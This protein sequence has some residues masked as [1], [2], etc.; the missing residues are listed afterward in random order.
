MRRPNPISTLL[1]I[2]CSGCLYD[3]EGTQGLPCNV[4]A[5]CGAQVCVD[6]VCGGGAALTVADTEPT[7]GTGDESTGS[8]EGPTA[9]QLPEPCT[10]GHQA[11]LGS[12]AMEVCDDDG[13]LYSFA[14][15]AWCG[16]GNPPQGS[17]QADPRDGVESCWCASQGGPP[18][19]TCGNSCTYDGECAGGER[20]WA[21]TSGNKCAP[22]ACGGCFDAGVGC[23][24]LNDSCQFESCG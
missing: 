20:C 3:G 8:D 9:Q 19:G 11:C 7:G 22:A 21:L 18:S 17:C 4:D 14:C 15:E 23:T 13:K 1:A 6:S 2:S 5:D 12:N 24:W 10:P 16:M